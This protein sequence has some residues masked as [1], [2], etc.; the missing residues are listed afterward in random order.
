MQHT[1]ALEL[2]VQGL[3]CKKTK[4]RENVF[5]MRV[6]FALINTGMR[7][8][9]QFFE[10][11]RDVP[12]TDSKCVEKNFFAKWRIAR[13]N[14]FAA[15]SCVLALSFF[16]SACGT[17]K[18]PARV[19]VARV[20]M[21]E[22]GIASWYGDPY[23]GR[24]AANGETF[25]MD[26]ASAAH[27]SLPFET[28]VRVR[29]LSNKRETDVRITDRG[30]FV[31]GR[32]IDL[33]RAAAKNIDMIRDGTAKVRVTVIEPPRAYERGREFSVQV[34]TLRE[35]HRAEQLRRSLAR[36][37]KEVAVRYRKPNA[38]GGHPAVWRV[39]VGKEKS[40]K[41]AREV[42]QRLRGRFPN[43]FVVPL[44]AQ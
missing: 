30:P 29:H 38:A 18:A 33:S 23:H 10:R 44:D 5:I 1:H 11:S 24:L 27:P 21:T 8:M 40:I 37:Y 42:L 2:Y 16:F 43:A 22:E 15:L 41:Q 14:R 35:E 12:R 36:D 17:R 19:P 32:I 20:G 39:L 6:H 28:W 3:F 31:K 13:A 4:M 25:D 26:S 7:T 34:S 9:L